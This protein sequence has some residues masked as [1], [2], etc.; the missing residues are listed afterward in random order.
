MGSI[1][2]TFS[3]VVHHIPENEN[4]WA[5]LG[6]SSSTTY[7]VYVHPDSTVH[8]MGQ[9]IIACLKGDQTMYTKVRVYQKMNIK[10]ATYRGQE[11]DLDTPASKFNDGDIVHVQWQDILIP[12]PACCC[13]LY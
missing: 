5:E 10:H 4:P 6:A 13:V 8:D 2:R 12:T 7:E 9:L 11:L 3:V 1:K